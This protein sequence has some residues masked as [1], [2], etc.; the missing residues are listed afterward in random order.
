MAGEP[1]TSGR[2]QV[3]LDRARWPEAY[4]RLHG[5]DLD[6]LGAGDLEVLADAAWWLSR[7][8]ESLAVR[9]RAHASFV[10]AGDAR[11]AGYNGDCPSFG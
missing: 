10:G 1:A 7:V 3:D 4:R 2:T 5:R 6:G 11:R 9:R 8:E